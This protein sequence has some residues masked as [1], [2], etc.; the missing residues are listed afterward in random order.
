[1]S[2]PEQFAATALG[3]TVGFFVG[4]PAGAVAGAQYGLLAGSLLFPADLPAVQGPR[5][6]DFETLH[7]DPGSPIAIVWGYACVSG[8]RLYL[9]PVTEVA[10]TEDVGGKGAPSQEVTTFT[11]YQTIALG[12]CE[13]PIV[14]VQRIWEN[15]ELVYDTRPQLDEE[16]D[17]QY[18]ARLQANAF[19]EQTFTLYLGGEDQLP[20]PTLEAELGEGNVSAFRDLAYIVYHS[21]K[22][23]PE[24]GNRHPVF[25]FEVNRSFR[26]YHVVAFTEP[27][28]TFY[29]STAQAHKFVV[30]EKVDSIDVLLVGGG[31]G[32]ST[33]GGG[34]GGGGGGVLFIEKYPVT[35]GSTLYAWVGGGGSA[36]GPGRPTYFEGFDVGGGGQGG[37]GNGGS[38]AKASGGGGSETGAGGIGTQPYGHNGG[39]GGVSL[40][41]GGSPSFRRAG[42][43]GGGAGG[44]GQGGNPPTKPQGSGG[45]GGPG[46]YFGDIFG[47]E[48]GH[49]GW[50]AGGGGGCLSSSGET[51]RVNGLGGLGGGV[52]GNLG[53]VPIQWPGSGGGGGGGGA[54]VS[55][56]LGA[57]GIVLI[58]YAQDVATDGYVRL[59]DIV[60][61]IC[62]RAGLSDDQYDTSELEDVEVR[63]YVLTR[64]SAARA[65]LEPIRMVGLFDIV[66]RDECIV[67]RRRGAEP[68]AMLAESD[69]GASYE[70]DEPPALITTT[71]TQDYEL[72]RQIRLRYQSYARDYEPGE[73]LS[74]ARHGTVGVNDVTVDC[75]VVLDD[76]AAARLAEIHFR[77]AWTSRWRHTFF[78]DPAWHAL[79]PGD[80]LLVPIDGRLHRVRIVSIDDQ[81]LMLRRVEAVRDDPGSYVSLAIATQP[82]R[83]EQI[84]SLLG[85]TDLELLDL[86]ALREED[87]NAGIYVAARRSGIGQAWQ[88]AWVHRSVDDGV[89]YQPVLALGSQAVIGEVVSAPA[90]G[91]VYTWDNQ[92]EYVVDI[93]SG[94][95]Q[96]RTDAAVI[97]GANMAAVGAHGR[98]HI[99]QFGR[100]ELVSPGRYRLTRL[101]LGRR[102][103]EHLVNKVQPGDAFVL[104]SG[105]GIYRLLLQSAEIGQSRIYRPV[106]N[107]SPFESGTDQTFTAGGQALETFAPVR[108]RGTRDLSGDLTISWIRRD[109][110][111]PTLRDGVPVPMSETT[112]AY[113]V[114]ILDGS[115]V[116]RTLTSSTTSAVYTAAQQTEDFG[117][118]PSSVTVRVYQMSSV[119]GRG[120][121]AEATI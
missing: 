36:G 3:A 117:S 96:S 121:P 102:G 28:S 38:A 17:E 32:G 92:G 93:L 88:G 7:A 83:G 113:E 27:N 70:G 45:D 55:G 40:V 65:A 115:N 106:T 15:G 57:S 30:P 59:S 14:G 24:Q 51:G 12:L 99:F 43:G 54:F 18:A 116:V 120:T 95:L 8:F 114:D 19:Y 76:N 63:G 62:G 75:P 80:V 52:N 73:Q 53:D 10:S 103:T 66:E 58:R 13:G 44:P 91:N 104:I 29:P 37:S 85:E 5:L 20:D 79:E 101:L 86:P 90:S 112:E 81:G 110:L 9:G 68:V 41:G 25:K 11:Y 111:S 31:G 42:G 33:V 107:G 34:G 100:A 39:A 67:F 46:V 97:S 23:K 21:R 74:P 87:D 48:Y 50:F 16:T 49:G 118:P 89:T 60:A 6:E 72:P 84:V 64:M 119:V 98:W 105:G 35:P 47:E 22:I 4:G 82:P 56:R 109:R 61:D 2:N 1:M 26:E 77:D 69:L 94:S 78:L 71:K 108:I